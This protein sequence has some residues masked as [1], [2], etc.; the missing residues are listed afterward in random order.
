MRSDPLAPLPMPA[1]G[2]A[3]PPGWAATA[4][5]RT[6]WLW[7]SGWAAL[8]LTLPLLVLL[9]VDGRSF[10]GVSVWLKP[11]K[12]H[13][14]VG[15][16]LLT[17]A[18]VAAALSDAPGRQRALGRLSAVAVVT[19]VFELAYI[20]WR[21]SR[22]E[23]SHF[24]VADPMAGLLYGLMGVGAVLLTGCAGMLGWW[25]ARDRRFASGPVLQRGLALG[26]LAGWLLGT[27]TGAVVSAQSGHWVGGTPSDAGGLPLLGW[28]R[29]GGDLRVAHFFGLHA[30]HVL[31]L[32]AWAMARWLPPRRA[33]PAV[34]LF[35]VAYTGWTLFTLLAAWRGQPLV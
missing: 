10:N 26:L 35:T 19:G 9:V 18:L 17:L 4:R 30:M 20:T 27:L 34:T 12:F 7:W 32:V 16:H 22:G 15:V 14:S 23:A 6:P 11:W 1:Q 29:D 25:V 24:N 5:S 33:L 13:L 2:L 8:A 3:A 31:P 21:A 28:S